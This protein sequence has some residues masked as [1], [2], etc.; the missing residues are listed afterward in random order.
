MLRR[1]LS[2]IKNWALG[3]PVPDA[4]DGPSP[5][6]TVPIA[7]LI[8]RVEEM[9]KTGFWRLDCETGQVY[10]S[11]QVFAIHE[12]PVS[13]HVDVEKALTYYPDA[14]AT[15]IAQA[16]QQASTVGTPYDL[17][18]DFISECGTPK[19]VRALGQAEMKNGKI[20]ALIGVFQD[21]SERY[22]LEQKLRRVAT[23]DELTGLP[24]RRHLKMYYESRGLARRGVK[25]T[26]FACVLIDL[27]HFKELNDSQGHA[28]G[29]RALEVV[30]D[31][32]KH[33]TFQDSFAAR[34][35][36]DEFVM[37]IEDDGLLDEIGATSRTLLALLKQPVR[38][39][40]RVCQMSGTIGI[41]WFD[42]KG[43]ALSDVLRCADAA[44]YSAKEQDRG[45]AVIS[46]MEDLMMDEPGD[47]PQVMSA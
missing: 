1:F 46:S 36:G 38:L 11:P 16:V 19:R 35:G 41:A 2:S 28:A 32:L 15:L 29:D 21:I 33:P 9:T 45:T 25:P 30:A 27:D 3:P 42:D 22:L 10:W 8:G 13:D 6:L 23:T 7:S 4:G 12:M 40:G 43:F 47:T 5:A 24:N 17:E 18:L 26:R 39:D 34:L 44:L 14:S 20:V 31:R 37:L